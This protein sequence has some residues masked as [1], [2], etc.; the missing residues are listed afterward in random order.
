MCKQSISTRSSDLHSELQSWDCFVCSMDETRE[1]TI[2]VSTNV[3]YVSKQGCIE[4][5]MLV[6][7][8]QFITL[9]VSSL[10]Q[11]V[12]MVFL[13]LMELSRKWSGTKF[14]TIVKFTWIVQTQ[15]CLCPQQSTLQVAFMTILTVYYFCM[16]TVKH[17]LWPMN[18]R[19]NRINFVFFTLLVQ[20]ILRGRVSWVN[21]DDDIGHENFYTD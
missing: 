13:S 9:L 11:G 17:L 2:R 8:D 20:Q 19:R 4:R 21:F 3:S 15:L 10:T 5:S 18:Y 7:G 14:G 1:L 12:Q 6:I 16:L